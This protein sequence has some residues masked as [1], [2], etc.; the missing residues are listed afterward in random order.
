MNR[1]KPG[2]TDSREIAHWGRAL[3]SAERELDAAR[4][5]Y[6]VAKAAHR[7]MEA[8][9]ELSWLGVDWRPYLFDTTPISQ[10]VGRT[11]ADLPKNEKQAPK[12]VYQAKD[13]TH[14]LYAHIPAWLYSQMKR[15]ME[16]HRT[17]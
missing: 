16:N 15:R 14:L 4:L 9:R 7:L 3:R 17:R 5:R 12:R 2:M 1:F 13:D 11:M 10:S 8:K 6:E